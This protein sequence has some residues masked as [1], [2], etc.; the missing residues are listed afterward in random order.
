MAQ[1]SVKIIRLNGAVLD[2]N[3]HYALYP[4]MTVRDN[5]E[6]GLEMAGMAK[7]ERRTTVE[8]AAR[9]LRL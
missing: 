3:Q 6:F 7:A 1:F 4:H 8:A 9:T 2:E 5:M